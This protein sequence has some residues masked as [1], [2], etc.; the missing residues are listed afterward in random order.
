MDKI[1]SVDGC[2]NKV[3]AKGYCDK[4]YRQYKTH[5]CIKDNEVKKV[6]LCSVEGCTNKHKALGYCSKHYFQFR[7][8]GRILKEQ[9]FIEEKN[10]TVMIMFNKEGEEIKRVK[11]DTE[12]IDKVKQHRWSLD[13]DGYVVSD[14]IRLHR[15]VMNCPK[16][17]IV[18][19]INHDVSD[20][21]KCNLRICSVSENNMN[22]RMKNNKL[23]VRNIHYCERDKCYVCQI[24]KDNKT[25]KRN[26]HELEDAIIWRNKKLKELHGEFAYIDD[27]Y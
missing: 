3:H 12:D 25:Y 22:S 10:Y 13:K 15:Y 27:E 19:H 26:F 9:K 8:H 21:R 11:I 24:S 18:D 23:G 14:S 7:E 6:R 1:C 2:N 4:H 5:G 16:G 17:K 20:N